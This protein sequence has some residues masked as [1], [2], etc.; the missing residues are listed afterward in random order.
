VLHEAF[1]GLEVGTDSLSSF[2]GSATEV[3]FSS[4]LPS[5]RGWTEL[6]R[7][8]VSVVN[9]ALLLTD[10]LGR[11][12]T[13]ARHVAAYFG[14]MLETGERSE[15]LAGW[16]SPATA[17]LAVRLILAPALAPPDT[18]LLRIGQRG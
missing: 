9:D 10:D 16:V 11:C 14:Y 17:P 2:H 5:A 3:S 4:N 8:R 12:D 1:R 15:W 6:R 7:L 18:V 13:L